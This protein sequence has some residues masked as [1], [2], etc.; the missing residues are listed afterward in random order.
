MKNDGGSRHDTLVEKLQTELFNTKDYD[1]IWKFYDYC[2]N[3]QVG[4]VDLL[5]LADDIWDQYEIK[6]SF[7][8]KSWKKATEQYN[9][10]CLAF[11]ERNISGF[12]YSGDGIIRRLQRK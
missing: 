10:F 6:C 1:H 3:G 11:P 4:E 12:F 2:R 8:S 9:R 5:A 7:N